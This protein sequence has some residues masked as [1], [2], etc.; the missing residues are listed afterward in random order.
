MPTSGGPTE[1]WS[2]EIAWL[3]G[4]TTVVSVGARKVT[5]SSAV[6]AEQQPSSK[7][8]WMWEVCEPTPHTAAR[9]ESASICVVLVIVP[10]TSTVCSVPRPNR[11][12]VLSEKNR[13][14]TSAP[15]G[16]KP[17]PKIENGVL[18]SASNV[19]VE[20]LVIVGAFTVIGNDPLLNDVTP[21]S[22]CTSTS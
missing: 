14:T 21:L 13:I 1:G 5:E 20:R 3:A 19:F 9:G 8:N 6:G 18:I 2:P 10:I 4:T 12:G 11:F 7:I 17:V 15:T 16:P 22:S